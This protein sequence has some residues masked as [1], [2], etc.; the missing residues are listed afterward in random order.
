MPNAFDA[1]MM[2]CQVISMA[3][4]LLLLHQVYDVLLNLA[5]NIWRIHCR[6]KNRQINP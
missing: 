2:G 6:L 4:I 1:A 5:W 3:A